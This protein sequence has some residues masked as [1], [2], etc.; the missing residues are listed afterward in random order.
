MWTCGRTRWPSPATTGLPRDNLGAALSD[1]G[2][3]DDA[4]THYRAAVAIF[5]LH[6]ITYLYIGSYYQQRGNPQAALEQYQKVLTLSDNA[7]GQ[8]ARL[9][10]MALVNMAA[11]YRDLGDQHPR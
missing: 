7:V 2:Q 11:I 8:Y 10:L 5:P 1:R 3:L 6:P 4:L 9:R